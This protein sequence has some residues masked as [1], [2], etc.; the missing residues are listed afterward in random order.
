MPIVSKMSATRP[1]DGSS[2]SPRALLAPLHEDA[3]GARAAGEQCRLRQGGGV[4]AAHG[5][6][7]LE[8]AVVE[9]GRP[10]LAYR[11]SWGL[12]PNRTRFSASKP[13]SV[14][15]RLSTVRRNAPAPMSRASEMPTWAITS[16]RAHQRAAAD[17]RA[18]VPPERGV[19]VDAGETVLNST[20]L[21]AL[22]SA[23]LAPSPRAR[24]RTTTAVHPLAFHACAR[25]ARGL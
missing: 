2:P 18:A 9:R 10:R 12:M 24:E 3:R 17:D 25:P 22:K 11:F 5:A 21:A 15:R 16:D 8:Q 20:P 23:V 1:G 14:C 4:H 13:R 7:P 19:H 6:Q